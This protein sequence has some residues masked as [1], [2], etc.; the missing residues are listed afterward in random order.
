MSV[1][2]STIKLTTLTLT[3]TDPHVNIMTTLTL[4]LT[5]PHVNIMTTLTLTLT[6]NDPHDFKF[7]SP[8]RLR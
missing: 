7:Y 1:L 6:L 3:L 8:Y 5:D 2:S 4:T